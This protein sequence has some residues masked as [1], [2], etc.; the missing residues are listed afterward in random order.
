MGLKIQHLHTLLDLEGM[1]GLEI[2][3]EGY[4]ELNLDIPK[5][6]GFKEDV[7]MLVVKDSEYGKKVPVAI[8]TL[9]IDMILDTATKEK[10]Q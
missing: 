6:K 2:P 10:L 3:Y 1:G 5:V 9:H 8:G 4:V 7:L